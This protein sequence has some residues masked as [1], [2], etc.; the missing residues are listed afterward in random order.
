MLPRTAYVLLQLMNEQ[1]VFMGGRMAGV[2]VGLWRRDI[3]VWKVRTAVS[4]ED[5]MSV[6]NVIF[7]I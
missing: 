4:L 2:V 5:Y 3:M 6:M 1:M 7:T